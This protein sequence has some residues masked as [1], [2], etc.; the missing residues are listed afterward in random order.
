MKDIFGKAINATVIIA[1]ILKPFVMRKIF[2]LY[3]RC[4]GHND[5]IQDLNMS[6]HNVIKPLV[7]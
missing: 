3:G 1:Y 2:I 4:H 6:E 5:K 7:F